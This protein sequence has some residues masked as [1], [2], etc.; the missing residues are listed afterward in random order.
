M[1]KVEFITNKKTKPLDERRGLT[2][3]DCFNYDI[4]EGLFHQWGL[5]SEEHEQNFG[6]DTV[7]IVEDL[8]GKIHTVFPRDLKFINK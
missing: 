3:L 1:R 6:I 2:G 5:Q 7:A 4:K 8:E